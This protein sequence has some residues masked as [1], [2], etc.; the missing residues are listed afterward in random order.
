MNTLKHTWLVV[1]V[2]FA[3]LR[4]QSPWINWNVYQDSTGNGQ[5]PVTGLTPLCPDTF[6]LIVDTTGMGAANIVGYRWELKNIFSANVVFPSAH[7][8]SFPIN[9]ILNVRKLGVQFIS[10]ALNGAVLLKVYFSSG[11]SIGLFKPLP[12]RPTP[13]IVFNSP[14]MGQT[15]CPGTPLTFS[16]NVTGADSFKVGYGPNPSDTVR[17]QLTF[18]ATAPSGPSWTIQAIAY[19]CGSQTSTSTTVNLSP[20]TAPLSI[21]IGPSTSFCPGGNVTVSLFPFSNITGSTS[22]SL[23][24]TGPG[25]FSQTASSLPYS[26]QLPTTAQAGTYNVDLTVTYP[27]GNSTASGAFTVDGPGSLTAPLGIFPNNQPYCEG[28]PIYLNVAGTRGLVSWD[29]GNDS[30]WDYIGTTSIQHVFSTVPS[31]GISIKIKQDIGCDSREDVLTWDR[32]GSASPTGYGSAF[33]SNVCPGQNVTFTIFPN[34]FGLSGPGDTLMWQASWLNSGNPFRGYSLDTV[35]PAP[36]VSGPATL[37]FILKNSCGNSTGSISFTVGGGLSSPPSPTILGAVC[38][39]GGTVQVVTP[40]IPGMISADYIGPNGTVLFNNVLPGDT[41]SVSVPSTGTTLTV[42]YNFGCVKSYVPLNLRPS[43]AQAVIQSIN[44]SPST[45]CPGGVVSIFVSGFNGQNLKVYHGSTLIGQKPVNVSGFSNN[46]FVNLNIAAPAGTTNLMIIVTGCGGNDT[47]YYTI[48][49]QPNGAV[50]GFNA[51]ISACVGQPVTFQ[52][53]GTNANVYGVTWYFGDNTAVVYDTSANVTH[54]YTQPGVYTVS[55][56]VSSACGYTSATKTI[57]VY[58]APPSLSGLSVTASGSQISY[59][60]IATN[61]DSVK[62][63]FNHPNT[64]PSALGTSGTYTYSSAGTYTVAA[65]AYNPCGT[66]TLTQT[67]TITTTSVASISQAGEWVLYPNPTRHE[68]FLVNSNYTGAAQIRLY[69]V[70]GRLVRSYAVPS[71]PARIELNVPAGLYQVQV[72]S[73]YGVKTL[74]LAVE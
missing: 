57:K 19:Y 40:P 41:I 46:F 14:T 6:W 15:V 62:W 47:A 23:S 5:T 29:I 28:T 27:C 67:V 13:S 38:S 50:A 11:D 55:L 66:D 43:N 44:V 16:L 20:S 24:I 69:D 73:E 65:I 45:T 3:L 8:G 35:L 63:L 34:N 32:S 72:I 49:A 56:G 60:V 71:L 33:P 31:G 7:T 39:G 1:G 68:A 74:R 51:P 4:A 12:L 10:G 52:R 25:G 2:L 61:A 18:T 17:N 53:T 64:T 26:F 9:G 58:S 59:T 70:Q 42:E 22:L 54:V 36:N 21:Q 48:S 37:N 30:S